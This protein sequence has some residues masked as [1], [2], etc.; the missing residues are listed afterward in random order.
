MYIYFFYPCRGCYNFGQK[1]ERQWRRRLGTFKVCMYICIFLIR[2][3]SLYC[4][5][6]SIPI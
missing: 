2:I 3:T 6:V 1:F 5:Y 4:S